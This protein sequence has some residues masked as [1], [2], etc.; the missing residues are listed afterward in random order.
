VKG[1]SD[2][3]NMEVGFTHSN[4]V[5]ALVGQKGFFDNFQ[6]TFERYKNRFD[7]TPLNQ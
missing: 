6:I 1:I 4:G 3:I 5:G 7:I 2:P